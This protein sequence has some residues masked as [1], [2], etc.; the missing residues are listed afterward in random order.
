MSEIYRWKCEVCEKDNSVPMPCITEV[1]NTAGWITIDKP[2][3]CPYNMPQDP[4]WQQIKPK[5]K[6][7]P[8]E[9]TKEKWK[10]FIIAV[11]PFMD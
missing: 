4:E 5:E 8:D 3:H 10:A 7:N 9:W 6:D 1:T 2:T 11:K